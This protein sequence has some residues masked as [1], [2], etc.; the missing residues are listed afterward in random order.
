M[1]DDPTNLVAHYRLTVLY[2]RAG[3]TADAQRETDTSAKDKRGKPDVF[4]R[5]GG[6]AH[7]RSQI[8]DRGRS[9]CDGIGAEIGLII[10][11]SFSDFLLG[12]PAGP[13]GAGGNGTPLSSVFFSTLTGGIHD[14][15]HRASAAHFLRWTTG[16]LR[17]TIRSIS[18]FEPRSMAKRAKSEVAR[19]TSSRN[20][21]FSPSG[22][23]HGCDH[24][25]RLH[26]PLGTPLCCFQ[27]ITK[28][29]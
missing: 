22:W 23:V 15:G 6:R 10:I 14:V 28:A 24:P 18:G 20:S 17:G 9:E 21:S 16:E 25:N 19:R 13:V 12:L 8:P 1:K 3:R 4:V 2:R 26:S 7:R 11:S 29:F 27:L 5:H